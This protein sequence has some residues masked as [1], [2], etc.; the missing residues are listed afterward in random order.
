MVTIFFLSGYV[1]QQ[2]TD[3]GELQQFTDVAVLQQFVAV[4]QFTDVDELLQ[5]TDV[6]SLYVLYQCLRHFFPLSS[7]VA[8]E[9]KMVPHLFF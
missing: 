7:V 8:S 1:L 9:N 4:L 5:F 3:V 6:A 2:F